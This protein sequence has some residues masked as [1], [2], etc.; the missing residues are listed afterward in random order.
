MQFPDPI[1]RGRFG[2]SRRCSQCPLKLLLC[3][4]I[5]VLLLEALRRSGR[6]EPTKTEWELLAAASMENLEKDIPSATI[7]A[8]IMN[9]AYSKAPVN[10]TLHTQNLHTLLCGLAKQ[11]SCEGSLLSHA[12]RGSKEHTLS[13]RQSCNRRRD[14]L[15]DIGEEK[16]GEVSIFYGVTP[17]LYCI[18]VLSYIIIFYYIMLY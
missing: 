8:T 11:C 1:L 3:L 17:V 9:I 6:S 13:W 12:L 4:L 14:T 10:Y 18:I 15:L 16:G 7:H 5:C 2:R